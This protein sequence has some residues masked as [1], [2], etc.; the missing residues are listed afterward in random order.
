MAT[1]GGRC[2]I[3]SPGMVDTPFFDQPKPTKLQPEDIADAVMFAVLA[4]PRANVREVFVT[5]TW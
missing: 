3:V 1:W 5:P 2:T 4:P